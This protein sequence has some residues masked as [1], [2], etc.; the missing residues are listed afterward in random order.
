MN[1]LEDTGDLLNNINGNSFM[2]NLEEAGEG[3]HTNNLNKVTDG[4]EG[5]ED[6]IK[7]ET[8]EAP[9]EEEKVSGGSGGMTKGE[10]R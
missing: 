8:N 6:P 10:K 9:V 7:T 3:N 1:N 2:S 5:S 4:S